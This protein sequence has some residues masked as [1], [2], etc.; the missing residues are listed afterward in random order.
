MYK[1]GITERGDAALNLSWEDKLN[2]IDGAILITKNLTPEFCNAALRNKD[3]V[4]IHA[5]ITGHGG[6]I[7]EPNVPK[8]QDSLVYIQSLVDCGF[9]SS[10]IVARVDPIIPTPKGIDTARKVI[11]A[12]VDDALIRRIRVSMI[13]MYPHVR[14]RFKELG[15]P[16]PYGEQGFSPSES[17]IAAVNTMLNSLKEDGLRIETCAEPRLTTAIQCGCISNIDLYTLRLFDAEDD[18]HGFQRKDCH[19]YDGKTELLDNKHQCAHNCV[20]CYWK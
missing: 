20:Y 1:I 12:I 11:Q 14:Q 3:K 5:T 17:Q 18:F 6:T 2:Q 19:C 13:D 16:L 9:P 7:L 10:K 4:I 8:F 15:L